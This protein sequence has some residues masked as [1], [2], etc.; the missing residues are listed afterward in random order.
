MV[1]RGVCL[2]VQVSSSLGALDWWVAGGAF[3]VQALGEESHGCGTATLV[4]SLHRCSW[5][6]VLCL[7]VYFCIV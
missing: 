5:D 4:T 3:S 2:L 7:K 6:V 1:G